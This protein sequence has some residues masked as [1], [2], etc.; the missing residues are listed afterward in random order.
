MKVYLDGAKSTNPE[1]FYN[2]Y[3]QNFIPQYEA[4]W[5]KGS[6]EINPEGKRDINKSQTPPKQT[7]KP[8][9]QTPENKTEK[10]VLF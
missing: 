1:D 2:Y 6:N 8:I 7:T 9:I 10:N 3:K 5:N 4:P